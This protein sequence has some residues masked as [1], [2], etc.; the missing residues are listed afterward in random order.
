[1]SE[2]KTPFRLPD[3]V[4]AGIRALV[5]REE[6]RSVSFPYDDKVLWRDLVAE[7]LRRSKRIDCAPQQAFFISGPDA[8]LNDVPIGEWGGVVHIP[9]E[10]M[11][12]GDLV[13]LPTWRRFFAESAERTGQLSSAIRCCCYYVLTPTHF[14]EL[15]CAS[16]TQVGDWILYQSKT[17]YVPCDPLGGWPRT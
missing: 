12:G 13:I 14:G 2:A 7:Q 1:M 16:R 9:Y 10:G 17:A 6:V 15:S 5:Q 8:G 3:P 4:A 11:C